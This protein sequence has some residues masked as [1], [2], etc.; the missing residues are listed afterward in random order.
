[1][2]ELGS[3]FES[4]IYDKQLIK[5]SKIQ[6][7]GKLQIELVCEKAVEMSIET[8]VLTAL[9]LHNYLMQNSSSHSYC[10]TGLCDREIAGGTTVQG[11]WCQDIS[12]ESFLPLQVPP[13]GHN[14]STDA[15]MILG[16]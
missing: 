4:V 6:H 9:T 7:V 3:H 5:E 14:S 13:C 15:K 8:L 1:T 11:S 12:S 2:S 10:P 16:K